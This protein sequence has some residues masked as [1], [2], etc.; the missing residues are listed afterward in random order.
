M[1]ILRKKTYYSILKLSPLII[2]RE[3]NSHT[4][5]VRL[6]ACALSH[7]LAPAA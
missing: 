6:N 2:R 7:A 4:F 3:L 1:D 5:S